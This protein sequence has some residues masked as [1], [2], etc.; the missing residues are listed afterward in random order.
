MVLLCLVGS[1]TIVYVEL[2][3]TISNQCATTLD[4]ILYLHGQYL[5]YLQKNRNKKFH[6][7]ISKKI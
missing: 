2:L 6:K 3:L 5:Q 7:K 1:K 4:T